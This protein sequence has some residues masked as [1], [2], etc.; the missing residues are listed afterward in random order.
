MPREF[1][2]NYIVNGFPW[3]GTK[4]DTAMLLASEAATVAPVYF[5]KLQFDS[6]DV[7]FHSA[8]GDITWGGETYTG[9]GTLG[10]I[11]GIEENADLVR[12]PISLSLTGLPNTL[13]SAFLNEQYQGRLATIYIGYLGLETHTLV[14]DPVIIYRGMMDVPKTRR[15]KTFSISLNIESRFAQWDRPQVRRYTNEDQRSRYSDDTGLQFVEQ[16]TENQITWGG[17]SVV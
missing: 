11:S 14:D 7:L 1:S 9:T 15:G 5:V 8:L 17:K 10:A 4:E 13:L 16:S 3:F 12:T 2:T 6:A